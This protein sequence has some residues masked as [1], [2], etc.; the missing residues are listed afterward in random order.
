MSVGIE[1]HG[2]NKMTK[3]D[4]TKEGCRH[5]RLHSRRLC[6]PQGDSCDGLLDT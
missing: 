4:Q 1:S 5:M 6:I 2:R 3:L